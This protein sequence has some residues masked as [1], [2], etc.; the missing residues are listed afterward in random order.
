MLLWGST[1][2]HYSERPPDR[3]GVCFSI[4]TRRVIGTRPPRKYAKSTTVPYLGAPGTWAGNTPCR[5][6]KSESLHLPHGQSRDKSRPPPQLWRRCH[7]SESEPAST[8]RC[9]TGHGG[10]DDHESRWRAGHRNGDLDW[11]RDSDCGGVSA[12][13]RARVILAVPIPTRYRGLIVTRKVPY[14]RGPS[15]M[16]LTTP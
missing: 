13:I 4:R 14:G 1:I 10:G 11:H 6:S 9:H 15:L 8:H 5:C 2:I 7:G 3:E 12:S 16:P